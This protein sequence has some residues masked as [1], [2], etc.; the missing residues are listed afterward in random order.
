MDE[1]FPEGKNSLTAA[2]GMETNERTI[3]MFRR[4]V[5]SKFWG[6]IGVGWELLKEGDELNVI[7]W[8]L[9]LQDFLKQTK[10]HFISPNKILKLQLSIF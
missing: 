6:E 4:A 10:T 5:T 3:V 1:D 8:N 7:F 9:A 2:Y